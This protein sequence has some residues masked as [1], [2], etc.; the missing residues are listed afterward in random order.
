M[1]R[2]SRQSKRV[3]AR[4]HDHHVLLS[5][6]SQVGHRIGVTFL[7]ELGFPEQLAGPRFEPPDALVVGPR[8]EDEP[9]GGSDGAVVPDPPMMSRFA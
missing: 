9:A 6:A 4:A 2:I 8:N 3:D 7:V 5:I 1:H